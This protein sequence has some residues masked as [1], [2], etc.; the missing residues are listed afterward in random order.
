MTKT[1][2]YSRGKIYKLVSNQTDQVYIGS[3]CR[4]H[5]CTRMAGH[6]ACY[7]AWLK[8]EFNYIT[9]FELVKFDDCQIVLIEHFPCKDKYEL[10]AR[11]RY[12]IENTVNVNRFIPT[13]SWKDYYECHRDEIIDRSKQHYNNNREQRL[14]KSKEYVE[15]N[16]EKIREYRKA[17]RASHKEQIKAHGDE[18]ITCDVCGCSVRRQMISRHKKSQKCQSQG[19]RVLQCP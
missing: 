2:D 6:R 8:G 16:R 19:S 3:T 13:R 4:K 18:K 9:C 15:S 17:Y 11:E 1:G 14:A 12:H 5:L 7:K 10:E